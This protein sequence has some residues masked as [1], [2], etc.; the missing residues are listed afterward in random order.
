[1]L[2]EAQLFQYRRDGYLVLADLFSAEE[3]SVLSAETA[4]LSAIHTP[5][6]KRERTGAA[7]SIMASHEDGGDTA[8][9][10]FRALSRCP[11][12]LGPVANMLETDELYIHHSKINVKQAFVGGIYSWHQDFGTWQ[13]DGI[14]GDEILTVMVMLDDAAEISGAL[15][16]VPGSHRAGAITHVEDL[17]IGALNPWSVD[18]RRLDEVLAATPPVPVLGRAGTTVI[19]HSNLVHGS[20]HNMS[21]RDRRQVYLVYNPLANRP[22]DV[23]NPR[24]EFVCSRACETVRAGRDD[25]ILAAAHGSS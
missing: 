22:H 25:G 2:T 6:I 19:F 14:R 21:N 24:P 3:V 17:G 9:P 7:R 16:F 4:R 13:R 18:R 23:A 1:M 5:L 15:Y 11:R 20:G 8:S 12:I 10:A